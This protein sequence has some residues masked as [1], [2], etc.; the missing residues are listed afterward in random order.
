MEKIWWCIRYRVLM[1]KKPKKMEYNKPNPKRKTRKRKKKQIFCRGREMAKTLPRQRGH[2]SRLLLTTGT[3][4]PGQGASARGHVHAPSVPGR[5]TTGTNGGGAFVPAAPSRLGNRDK[6]PLKTGT[7]GPISTSGYIPESS[8]STTQTLHFG[9]EK[10]SFGTNFL[11]L[12]L[13]I[14]TRLANGSPL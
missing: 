4:G 7:I 12:E 8:T 14:C 2:S 13:I 1:G 11:H 6:W 5:N 9:V 10:T 3:N